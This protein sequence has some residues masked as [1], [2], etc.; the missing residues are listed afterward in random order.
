MAFHAEAPERVLVG[1]EPERCT[2][3]ELLDRTAHGQG[4]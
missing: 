4:A 1:R 2:R 3:R